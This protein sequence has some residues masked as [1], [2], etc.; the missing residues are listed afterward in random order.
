MRAA[1][2][3]LATWLCALAAAPL[4]G[5]FHVDDGPCCRGGVCCHRPAPSDRDCIRRACTCAGHDAAAPGGPAARVDA[6][7]ADRP[8]FSAPIVRGCLV[9]TAGE[10]ATGRSPEP[11]DH[12]P[13]ISAPHV[14]V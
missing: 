6:L 3:L 1:A 11:L 4:A 7:P 9:V 13:R 10:A 8:P 12:P 14:L 5:A 2:G